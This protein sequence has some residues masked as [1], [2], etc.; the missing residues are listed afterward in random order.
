MREEIVAIT[1]GRADFETRL[2]MADECSRFLT[3]ALRHP[4]CVP[5]IPRHRE[6]V[7]RFSPKLKRAFWGHALEEINKGL[8]KQATAGQ[9][10]TI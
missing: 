1:R 8:A 9:E 5:R 10:P 2:R 6:G 3:W 4:E 7:G